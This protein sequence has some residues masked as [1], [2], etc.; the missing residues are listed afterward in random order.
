MLLPPRKTAV[1]TGRACRCWSISALKKTCPKGRRV[2]PINLVMVGLRRFHH[3]LRGWFTTFI[4]FLVRLVYDVSPILYRLRA[5]SSNRKFA[6]FFVARSPTSRVNI[7]RPI[8]RFL[9]EIIDSK[10]QW[11]NGR[12]G[13]LVPRVVGFW[14]RCYIYL[15]MFATGVFFSQLEYVRPFFSKINLLLD[16]PEKNQPR[17][18]I[19]G[20]SK[21]IYLDNASLEC[22]FC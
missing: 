20:K 3:F 2:S 17:H 11:P 19:F 5:L 22:V 1:V 6:F 18:K 7:S 4:I 14:L 10:K 8:H 16:S 13:L 9:K 21:Q 15:G 12:F